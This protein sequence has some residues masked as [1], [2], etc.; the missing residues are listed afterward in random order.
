[1][2]IQPGANVYTAGFGLSPENVQVPHIDT[3][4]AASSD[5]NY[6]IGKRWV[7]KANNAVFVLTSYSSAG[8][9]VTANWQLLQNEGSAL[10]FLTGNSGGALS[11]T[12]NNINIVATGGLGTFV[13]SGSTLTY[14]PVAGAYPITPFTVGPVGQAGYQTIQSAI[15]AANTAGGGTVYIQPGTYTENLTLYTA[16]TLVAVAVLGATDAVE[17]IGVHT[18]PASGYF[19]ARDLFFSSTTSIFS[20][21]VAGTATIDTYGCNFN[22]TS[23]YTFNLTAWTGLINVLTC[24]SVGANDGFM[25]NATGT[26][27]VN[28]FEATIG[29]G[30]SN[31]AVLPGVV[32]IYNANVNCP[33]NLSGTYTIN[34]G[35]VLSG[36]TTISGAGTG[37]I[38]GA[39]LSTGSAEA[40]TYS[41]SAAS[42]INNCIITSSNTNAI[43]GAGA[44]VLTLGQL[45]FGGTSSTIQNTLTIAWA[46]SK[47]GETL[48]TGSLVNTS[49]AIATTATSGFIYAS[50]CAGT[51]TGTPTTFTGSVPLV[52]DTSTGTGKLWAYIGGAWVGIALA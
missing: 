17:I 1:M 35:C 14:T 12:A 25:N 22:A 9:I 47:L 49:G 46:I 40:V 27:T 30:N 20:S 31:S 33:L 5:V 10:D 24:G 4:N 37:A 6:P 18:P 41:S 15:N 36:T 11:P 42:S 29:G 26:A 8:G 32:G 39:D 21:A 23:G 13:G 19:A 3:R 45:V 2:S 52:I 51:P 16:V 34:S 43:G 44:G 50:S 28:V 38:F 48:V 7:N